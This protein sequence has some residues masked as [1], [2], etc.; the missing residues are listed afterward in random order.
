MPTSQRRCCLRWDD[1]YDLLVTGVGGTGVVTVGA[2]ITMAAHLERRG[3]SVLDFMG[4]A[5]KFGP[6]LSYI[7]FAASPKHLNQVRIDDQQADAVIGCDL[8]VSSSAKA[9]RTYRRN[10]TR[11]A[12]N[13]TEMATA[14]FVLHRGANLQAERRLAEIRAITG[15]DG[16]SAVAANELAERLLGNTIY[17]NVL[18][19]GFAW[20]EG[21]VPVSDRAML[22]AIELNAV[23]VEKNRAAFLW[24]RLAAARPARVR[25]LAYGPTELPAQAE[26]LDAALERRKAFLAEYQDASLVKR[27][28]ELVDRVMSAEAAAGDTSLLT[29]SV[30]KAAF[31]VFA[32]K[33]E[34]E[35]ARLHT[36]PEF[37]AKIRDDFGSD[38]RL[39]FHLAPPLLGGSPDARGRPGKREFGPWL[40]PLL[41]LLSRLRGLRGS[42]LDPFGRSADRR[43]E[44]A[45]L[46]SFERTVDSILAGLRADNVAEATQIVDLFLEIRGYGP[47]KEEAAEKILPQVEARLADFRNGRQQAA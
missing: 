41:R 7:R 39:R 42:W 4:F 16:L 13:A 1:C 47:V 45:L 8:V 19:L 40:L 44:R 29:L 23:D 21:L 35:V 37:L 10:H 5:Q 15:D 30:V 3:A 34:Y 22:R 32:Y 26:S 11:A 46:A 18:L 33:D 14:D 43:L 24:G 28:A 38:A 31:R 17:A 6:V 36:R 20:Q 25:E 12:V 9:S 27:Y 2:L